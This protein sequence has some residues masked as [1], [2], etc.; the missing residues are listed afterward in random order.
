MKLLCPAPEILTC[1][2]EIIRPYVILCICM[3]YVRFYV[4]PI[5][6]KAWNPNVCPWD[7]SLSL[8][9]YVTMSD[10]FIILTFS[11]VFLCHSMIETTPIFMSCFYSR[12]RIS[13]KCM[14]LCNLSTIKG[15]LCHFLHN[16]VN[17]QR[18]SEITT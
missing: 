18:I 8:C 7:Q 14:S 17:N 3:S 9:L 13:L 4:I 6:V 12:L 15:I 10:I 1:A 5:S 11:Y 2:L 16:S